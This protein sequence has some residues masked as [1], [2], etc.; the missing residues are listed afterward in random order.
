MWTPRGAGTWKV[1]HRAGGQAPM[2]DP[3]DVVEAV[4]GVRAMPTVRQHAK[5]APARRSRVVTFATTTRSPIR[6]GQP[7]DA[8]AY[9]GTVT[10]GGQ[11]G[12]HASPPPAARRS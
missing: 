12:R 4:A 2:V 8:R 3:L 7:T 6:H 11:H 9:G 10:A 5:A 1:L